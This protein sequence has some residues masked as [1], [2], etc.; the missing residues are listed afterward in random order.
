MMIS[1]MP[2]ATILGAIDVNDA[3]GYY[4]YII[5]AKKFIFLTKIL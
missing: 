4:Q 1:A 5:G 2:I 3:C